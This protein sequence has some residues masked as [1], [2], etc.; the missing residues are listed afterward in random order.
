MIYPYMWSIKGGYSRYVEAC[1]IPSWMVISYFQVSLF[2]LII[3]DVNITTDDRL[4][5]WSVPLVVIASFFVHG[6][7]C[8]CL[9]GVM[10]ST[11]FQFAPR[12]Q[13]LSVTVSV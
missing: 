9:G 2:F 7:V 3:F 10:W 1:I 12:D 13:D 4:P 11:T 5:D 8:Y 6:G